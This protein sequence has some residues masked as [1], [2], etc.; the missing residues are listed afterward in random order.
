MTDLINPDYYK[1]HKIQVTDAISAWNLNFTLGN[2][3]KYCV[4][5][6]SKG[7]D[8]D[9][10]KALWYICKEL[11]VK[12]GRKEYQNFT[13]SHQQNFEQ[14]KKEQS[15]SV[16]RTSQD[17]VRST[18]QLRKHPPTPLTEDKLERISTAI[19]RKPYTDRSSNVEQIKYSNAEVQK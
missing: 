17:L 13:Q 1:K 3:V 12:Y 7:K 18:I 2:V 19:V 10:E 8:T 9:L 16:P 14:G 6:D 5:A 11:E 4:R 15:S